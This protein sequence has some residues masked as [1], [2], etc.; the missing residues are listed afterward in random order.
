MAWK[1]LW[2]HLE[3]L[4]GY[5][6]LRNMAWKSFSFVCNSTQCQRALLLTTSCCALK[7][8]RGVLCRDSYLSFSSHFCCPSRRGVECNH[9]QLVIWVSLLSK[10]IKVEEFY[11]QSRLENILLKPILR[12]LNKTTK[13]CN[14]N[15]LHY[16]NPVLYPTSVLYSCSKKKKLS[17][18]QDSNLL[19]IST[20][21]NCIRY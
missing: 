14:G 9:R 11:E 18:K 12:H 10:D 3:C 6:F 16:K 20:E 5:F 13:L 7:G 2:E 19:E 15:L 21:Q 17:I 1:T 8:L 4:R